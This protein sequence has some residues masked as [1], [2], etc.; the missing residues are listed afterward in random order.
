MART[1]AV[2]PS[3]KLPAAPALPRSSPLPAR[4]FTAAGSLTALIPPGSRNA[5]LANNGAAPYSFYRTFDLTGYN[6]ATVTLSGGWAVDDAGTLNLNGHQIASLGGG[7]AGALNNFSIAAGS[8]FLNPGLNTL[9][10]TITS[11]DQSLEGVR[12]EGSVST[13]P[14]PATSLFSG[15]T[16][17]Y[18]EDMAPATVNNLANYVLKDSSNNVYHLAPPNYAGGST[19]TYSIADG[20][21][22]PGNYTLA[23]GG[24]TDRFGNAI[25]A[26]NYQFTVAGVAGFTDLG[27]SSNNAAT[28]TALT[29]TE[30]PAGTGLFQA[31]GRGA[32]LNNSDVDYWTFNGTAGNLLTIATQ[33]P[34]SPQATGLNY[35]I[36]K[37]NGS[38]LTSFTT[39]YTGNAESP[40]IALPTTGTYTVSVHI[41]YGYHGEY[42]FRIVSACA[43][44]AIGHRAQQHHRHR[45]CS[46]AD[47]ERLQPGRQCG[48]HAAHTER[49]QLFQSWKHRLRPVDPAQHAAPLD[50]LAQ[51]RRLDL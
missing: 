5:N 29:L 41:Y 18:S 20:P 21:L 7:N 4:I 14:I 44:V 28:P 34:G 27:R 39:D 38:Q 49:S 10:I 46:H 8:P 31:G 40:P 42:R 48:R 15:F 9:S 12:F 50:Q 33:N 11:D 2:G 3:I 36:S 1:T 51:P 6:L 26:A 30:D 23:I 32:L 43:A 47:N 16:L 37:P 13:V 45:Q 17:S 19:A 25:G 35:I 22:Q 24:L